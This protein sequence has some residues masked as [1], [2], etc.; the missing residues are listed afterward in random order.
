MNV[1]CFFKQKVGKK[2][3]YAGKNRQLVT[4]FVSRDARIGII[5]SMTYKLMWKFSPV[6]CLKIG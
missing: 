2:L 4:F 3:I 5:N 1:A 6:I